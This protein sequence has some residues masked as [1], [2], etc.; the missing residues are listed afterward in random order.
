MKYASTRD[1]SVGITAAEAIAKGISAEGGLFVPEELPRLTE[2]DFLS[3]AEKRYPDLAF[4]VLKPFLSAFTDD[5]I[6]GW[7]YGAYG[8]NFGVEDAVGLA[9]L[10]DGE[11]LL[12]LWHG[13][14]AAFKDM[15]LQILPGMLSASIKKTGFSGRTLILAATS[16]DTGKAALE[17]FKDV[18]GV[19]IAVF[20]PQNGVSDMQKLQ[21]ATQ[22][23]ENVRVFAVKGN[24]DDCQNGVKAVFA[25]SNAVKSAESRGVAF[26]S[27]NSIN[28]GRL[29]PQIAYYVFAYARLVKRGEI[30]CGEEINVT[31]PTGNFGNILAAYYAREM[32]TPIKTL[33][34]AS[35]ANNV[36]TDFINTGIY[37]RNREFLTTVS[38]SMDILVSSN[39]ERLLY[40]I[41]GN[42][43][44]LINGWF[45]S[46]KETGRYVVGAK[47][48]AKMKSAF[49]G[50]WCG[51]DDTKATVREVFGKYNYL[52]DTHTA[53]GYKV[54]RDYAARTGD[55]AKTVIASTA[56][57]YKFGAAV[58]EA[59]SGKPPA[60]SDKGFGIIKKLEKLSGVPAP[61]ALTAIKGKKIRF[62]ESVG[63]DGIKEAVLGML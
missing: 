62:K 14:T 61:K 3:L 16:G 1:P 42:N 7:V 60:K 20:Y 36:L 43:P 6:R 31:V 39:L 51:E 22:E 25:D 41:S 26:S 49:C 46:L 47:I 63:K 18:D 34:C 50:G 45:S 58:Y 15:A 37:D 29:C 5:E 10:G 38:P 30:V 54:Y 48:T 4:E 27:A 40:H 32:G 23:G 19:E 33:I 35:N 8:G 13:P 2:S 59:L 11:F 53:V 57:P 55:N 28:W 21:M 52:M 24:F 56:N 44:A 17:G 12:E 9:K